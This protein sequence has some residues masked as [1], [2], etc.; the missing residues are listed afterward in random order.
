[1]PGKKIRKLEDVALEVKR[2]REQE[3][4]DLTQIRE[5]LEVSYDVLNQLILQS[6]KSVMNTP[7][8]FEVQE[9]IRLGI[10]D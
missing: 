3:G 5:K 7:V 2:L 10:E 8:V 4:L 6:Y 1:M 9:K